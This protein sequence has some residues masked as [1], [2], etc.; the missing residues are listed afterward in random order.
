MIVYK[1]EITEDGNNATSIQD[2]YYRGS[3]YESEGGTG[4]RG[5]ARKYLRERK[6]VDRQLILKNNGCTLEITTIFQDK[7]TL[8]S[9]MKEDLHN[10]ARQFFDDRH[11]NVKIE[12]YEIVEEL[13]LR[14]LSLIGLIKSFNNLTLDEIKNKITHLFRST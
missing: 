4:I 1:Q 7:K 11:W 12:I 10:D 14:N 9:F 2:F 8:T 6:I 13:S 5:L 3:E